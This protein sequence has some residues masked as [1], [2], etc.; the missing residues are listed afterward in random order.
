MKVESIVDIAAQH[1][2]ELIITGRLRPGEQIKEDDIAGTLDISRPP[3]RE[4][5]NGL[6]G[7]GLVVRRPRKG[8]FVSEMAE[9]D[10]WEV[11]TLKAELYAMATDAAIDR[12]SK[13]QARQLISLVERMGACSSTGK[14]I[15]LKYQK[16]HWK[17]H[18]KIMEIAGNQR[19]FRFASNLHKQIRR[20]SFQT[21]SYEE[22]LLASHQYHNRIAV[23]IV[24]KDRENARNLMREHVLDAMNFLLNIPGILEEPE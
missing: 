5:L 17:F 9:K 2:E 7:E 11:Y 8:A 6:E 4:A 22:H 14:K 20:Y 19:L 24:D 10:I 15:I 13:S 12:I 1:I 23:C 18:V 16:L 3:V 21:L